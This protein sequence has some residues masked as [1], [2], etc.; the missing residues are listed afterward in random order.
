[1][2]AP[3]PQ[4]ADPGELVLVGAVAG[5]FGVRGEVRLKS[6]T[7]VPEDVFDYT[8]FLNERGDT[9]LT[10][11]SWRIIKGGFAAYVSE[12]SSRE[13]AEAL[14]STALYVARA[15]LPELED[16]EFYQA[17][18][19]GLAVRDQSGRDLG[20][21]KAVQNFGAADLLEIHQTPGARGSWFL[22]FT[23]DTAPHVDVAAGVILV[24]PPEGIAPD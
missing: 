22:P 6:F 4:D 2:S 10:V 7:D 24:D 14:K 8:P 21:V 1:M 5:A 18:L 3:D 11:V 12:A 16:D 15:R 9:V 13:D 19:V 23:Q 17:D 20:R